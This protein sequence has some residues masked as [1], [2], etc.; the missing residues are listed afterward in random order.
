[1]LKKPVQRGRSEQSL[2]WGGWDDPNCARRTSTFLSCAFREQG[3]RPSYPIP[4]FFSIL[5]EGEI[6]FKPSISP[7]VE[8][9]VVL[10]PT[11][12]K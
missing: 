8:S 4:S 10:V 7:A 3:D 2:E 6:D 11:P 9:R 5:L 1:M 12:D